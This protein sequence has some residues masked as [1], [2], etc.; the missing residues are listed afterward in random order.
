MKEMSTMSV[1]FVALFLLISN[2]D[3]LCVGF[4]F[5]NFKI[6]VRMCT[7]RFKRFT[8]VLTGEA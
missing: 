5:F 6:V 1:T 3:G 4:L 2:M 7:D 8:N